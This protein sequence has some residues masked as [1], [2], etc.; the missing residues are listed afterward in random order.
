VPIAMSVTAQ[1]GYLDEQESS[2][3]CT[4]MQPMPTTISATRPPFSCAYVRPVMAR[5]IIGIAN[6]KS[7]LL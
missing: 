4:S 7:A 6:E 1:S 2:I 5:M 3:P